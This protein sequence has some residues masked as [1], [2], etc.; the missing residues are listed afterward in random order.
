MRHKRII[1]AALICAIFVINVF[2][3]ASG[4]SAIDQD[5]THYVGYPIKDIEGRTIGCDCGYTSGTCICTI[6]VG[7]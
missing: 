6:H 3:L 1:F 5:P 2:I 4:A 7:D